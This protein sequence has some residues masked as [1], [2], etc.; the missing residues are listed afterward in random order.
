MTGERILNSLQY[1]EDSLV[2]E[3]ADYR[4]P[5][6]TIGKWGGLAACLALLL[7]AALLAGR[8]LAPGRCSLA[9]DPESPGAGPASAVAEQPADSPGGKNAPVPGGFQADPEAPGAGPASAV[10]EQPADSP[11]QTA[12]V[13]GNP[14][15]PAPVPDMFAWWET[16][17]LPYAGVDTADVFLVGE[18]LT[19]EQIKACAPEI[20]PE[21]MKDLTGHAVYRL[22]DGSGGLAGVELHAANEDRGISYRISLR[23]ATEQNRSVFGLDTGTLPSFDDQGYRA[24]REHYARGDGECTAILAVFVREGVLYTLSADVPVERE[25]DAAQDLRDLLLAYAGTRNVPDLGSFR[26]SGGEQG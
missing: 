2:E 4:S 24:Y 22:A 13:P 11:G 10:P 17:V 25:N 7:G 19:E 3:A 12:P 8:A 15:E 9:A 16:D 26:Y 23:E 1:V 21:W 5:R 18:D 20:R 6:R 14:G